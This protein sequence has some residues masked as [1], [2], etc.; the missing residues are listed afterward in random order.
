M[1]GFPFFSKITGDMEDKM[2]L[3]GEMEFVMPGRGSISC[4]QLLS[5]I[6]VPGTV[7]LEP[8]GKCSVLVVAARLPSAS[9]TVA[10]VVLAEE[11]RDYQLITA[12]LKISKN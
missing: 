8:N 2:R 7:T 12:K 5:S 1:N 9:M 11:V 3:P 6:P 4:I 10:V